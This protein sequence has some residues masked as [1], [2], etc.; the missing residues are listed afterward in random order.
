MEATGSASAILAIV[1]VRAQFPIKLVIFAGQF[2]SS[3]EWIS[4]IAEY[5]SLNASILQQIGELAKRILDEEIKQSNDFC[6]ASY[7]TVLPKPSGSKNGIF[8]AA[9]LNTVLKS[10]FY[11]RKFPAL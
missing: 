4:S 7:E 11:V 6:E 1:A 8:S 2:R 5:I 3:T 9:G 10:A